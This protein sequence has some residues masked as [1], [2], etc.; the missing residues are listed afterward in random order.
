MAKL[1]NVNCEMR[2]T[3]NFYCFGDTADS[4]QLQRYDKYATDDIKRA[5]ELIKALKEYRQDL[6][7]HYQ[8]VLEISSH[9]ELCL[10]RE[11]RWSTKK[12]EYHVSI[13]RIYKDEK[14]K[15]KTEFFRRFTG[16]ERR[17]AKALFE[18]MKKERPGI[19]CVVDIK[20][21]HWEN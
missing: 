8:K 12:V 4:E 10:I 13:V 17:E 21:K 3:G 14:I 9:Q 16:T 5:E 20:K 11:K 2:V 7:V 6:F 15:P 19:K 18:K 1:Y